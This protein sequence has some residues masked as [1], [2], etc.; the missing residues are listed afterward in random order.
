MSR[1]K[2][3]DDLYKKIKNSGGDKHDKNSLRL[4]E[5]GHYF[6]DKNGNEAEQ[7]HVFEDGTK[8]KITKRNCTELGYTSVYDGFGATSPGKR[9]SNQAIKGFVDLFNE[10]IGKQLETIVGSCLTKNLT[11]GEGEELRYLLDPFQLG[12]I[13]VRS[14]LR[15]LVKP[16]D[17]KISTSGVRFDI[18][19][20]VE[21]AIKEVLIDQHSDNCVAR[22]DDHTKSGKSSSEFKCKCRVSEK[23]KMMDMLRR[24][25]KLGDEK[26]VKETLIKLAK[27]VDIEHEDWNKRLQG[28]IGA[29]LLQILFESKVETDWSEDDLKFYDLFREY[30]EIQRRTKRMKYVTLTD[31]G[32]LWM[33]END[34]FIRDITL[35]FLPMVIEPFDW[36]IDHGGYGDQTIYDTYKL[37]KGYSRGK[38]KKMYEKH[39]Q[40][41]NTLIKTINTLQKTPF[42]VNDTVW[43]AVEFVH[44]NKI[45]LDRK[46]VPSY[47]GGWNKFIGKEKSK[48]FFILK[49][50]L[51]RDDDNRLKPESKELLLNFARSVIEGS[52]EMKEKDVW[53]EWSLLRRVVSKHSRSEKSKVILIENTLNDSAHFH[54]EECNI[55]NKQILIRS[56]NEVIDRIFEGEIEE[57]E[58]EWWV[59][60]Y[61]EMYKFE[62][63]GD[64]MYFCYNADYRGR[65]YPLAGQFSPQGS[66]ISRGM[67]EFANGVKVDAFK[68]EDAVR[69]IAIVC[70]NNFGEDKISLDDRAQWAEDHAFEMM[71][72]ARDFKENQWWM[73]A[74]KPFLFLQ[75]C[76]E[77][78]KLMDAR[79]NDEDNSFISTLPI[80]FD[81]SCN[82]IQ[83]Y[84]ALFLDS[85]GAEAVNLVKSEVP[86]DVYQEVANKA[87]LIA[88]NSK[89]IHEKLVVKLNDQLDGKLFGRKVAKRSVMTLPYGVSKRSSNAYVVEE[90][91]NL[92]RKVALTGAERKGVRKV[93][94]NL[95]WEAILL[96]VEKPVTGKEYFQEVAKEMAEHE[97]GLL[98]FTPTGLPVEQN[99][100]KRDVTSNVVKI[101]VNGVTIRA[102]YPRYTSELDGGEQA[103]A[104]APNYV[105]SFDSAH[106]QFSINAA[107]KEGMEN[108]LVI[109]DSFSTDA[110]NAG[111]FNHIIREQ[112]VK[113]YS[114]RDYINKFHED[115]NFQ[116]NT[117]EIEGLE[118]I[119]I[120]VVELATPKEERGDFDILEVLESEYFFS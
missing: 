58:K 59:N 51:V 42:K 72:C 22:K 24:Q 60:Y 92:L 103:N 64:E 48:E 15:S 76:M 53:K 37:I 28:N 46:G 16:E 94:G 11:A 104:V 75:S 41:F 118:G 44:K 88:E 71:E 68:D 52:S 31:L 49:K 120:G 13:V 35:S 79:L 67:L 116:L 93:M 4:A 34:V 10:T 86:S 18:G 38:I 19:E 96:V 26:E 30:E 101:T 57:D 112:F 3:Q 5:N 106:L 47:V 80:A 114:G 43:N 111:R 27:R 98:W 2:R 61:Y 8:V 87:L 115:C 12:K 23:S 89:G 6:R 108:F 105:H 74:D 107:A 1:V 97:K 7:P 117:G 9:F 40:G 95:I 90:V 100:K 109:H 81:G 21:F 20:S 113:M 82:G 102:E 25:E 29:S 78:T 55:R 73:E 33:E 99:L 32:V 70:A 62:F 17:R 45:N 36:N 77:W 66:D 63:F 56:E 84:S 85:K 110:I 119:K 69:Q 65:I 54:E 50:L 91:D 83:H 14:L 39:P